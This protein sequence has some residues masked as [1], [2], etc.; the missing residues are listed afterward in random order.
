MLKSFF[1]YVYLL[2]SY[3]H[4]QVSC[5]PL[6]KVLNV[7]PLLCLSDDISPDILIRVMNIGW[8]DYT[9]AWHRRGPTLS[10]LCNGK[11]ETCKCL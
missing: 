6:Y 10:T 3:K 5:L 11:H 9:D 7:G 2:R 8:I 1:R 4:L